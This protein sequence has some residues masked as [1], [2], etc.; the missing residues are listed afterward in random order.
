MKAS[1]ASLLVFIFLLSFGL[2]L[3][4]AFHTPRMV[5]DESLYTYAGLVYVSNLLSGKLSGSAYM[6]NSAHPDLAKLVFGFFAKAP[7]LNTSLPGCTETCAG[8][9]TPSEILQ[10][11]I[12]DAF[13]TSFGP[14]MLYELVA[15]YDKLGAV[16]SSIFLATYPYFVFWSSLAYLDAI[17]A[18][19][20]LGALWFFSRSQE[21]LKYRDYVLSGIFSGLSLASKYFGFLTFVIILGLLLAR[22]SREA[23]RSRLR[24]QFLGLAI[25][26]VASLVSFY[27]TNP[28]IWGQ[29][30]VLFQSVAPHF[31]KMSVL[32]NR[33][34]YAYLEW[35]IVKTPPVALL[36]VFAGLVFGAYEVASAYRSQAA[37]ET[38]LALVYL[39]VTVTFLTLLHDKYDHYFTI[40]VP[41]VAALGG[42]GVGRLSGMIGTRRLRRIQLRWLILGVLLALHF[43]GLIAVYAIFSNYLAL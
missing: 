12:G 16:A 32:E 29:P 24:H 7:W 14:L 25:L 6:V 28:M 2:R 26:I 18:T 23:G 20:M 27:V 1:N 34:W 17:C 15:K 13:L 35:I 40:A 43:I 33:P 19:F 8:L 9:A 41:A 42:I 11:R 3:L 38:T 5:D 37:Q 36:G 22:W 39:A 21:L 4:S 10:A 31:S 30:C